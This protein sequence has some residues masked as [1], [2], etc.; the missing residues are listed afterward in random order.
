[1]LGRKKILSIELVHTMKGKDRETFK[2]LFR[3]G[4]TSYQ[5]VTIDSKDYKK[6]IKA[7]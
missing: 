2:F 3:D 4:S 5:T 1:M 7:V 6:F